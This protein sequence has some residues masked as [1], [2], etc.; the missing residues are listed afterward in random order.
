[1]FTLA[2]IKVTEILL[3]E[4]LYSEWETMNC[5]INCKEVEFSVKI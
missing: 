2:E 3:T 5:Q 4:H 1:M